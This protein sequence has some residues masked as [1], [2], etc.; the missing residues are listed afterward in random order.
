MLLG[1]L[2]G[3]TLESIEG[4]RYDLTPCA[5]QTTFYSVARLH[6]KDGDA[7]DLRV[8]PIR[9]DIAPDLWDDV[10]V[11]SFDRAKGDIWLPEGVKAFKLPIRRTID[12]VVLVNDRDELIHEGRK[13]S[14]FAFTKAVLLR[15][16]LEFIA[17]AIDDFIEDSIVVRRGFSPEE[18]VPAGAGSWYDEP[19]WTDNY[20]REYEHL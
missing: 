14:T 13:E 17:L 4:Y 3:K 11:Y 2:R 8:K 7:Y 12:E 6:M 18:L 20:S 10:G 1:T 9:V 16:S 5:E 15:T 19:G